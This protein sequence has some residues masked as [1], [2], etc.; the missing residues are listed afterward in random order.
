MVTPADL[1]DFAVRE[2]R[3]RFSALRQVARVSQV[4]LAHALGVSVD[5]VSRWESGRT[6]VPAWVLLELEVMGG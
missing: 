4:E 2:A 5:T 3:R 1:R 6:Q